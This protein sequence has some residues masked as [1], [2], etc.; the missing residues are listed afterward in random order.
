MLSKNIILCICV[1][2][3]VVCSGFSVVFA[4]S[5]K[6]NIPAKTIC[7]DQQLQLNGFGTRTKFFI[8][9]YV[10]SLYVQN[11]LSDANQFLEMEQVSCMRLQITSSKITSK[12]MIN[13][14]HEGFEKATKGNT[15]PIKKEIKTFSSYLEQPIKKGDLFEF[16]YIPHQAIHIIKNGSRL[17]VIENKEFAT[18]FFAI[19]LGEMPAQEKLKHG[20]LGQL[21]T[22]P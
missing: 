17:G 6:V 15:D 13:A 4:D 2:L 18:A 7:A 1:F 14:I 22:L 11:R 10:A 21:Q 5:V 8:K 16:T 12:K 20:L 3:I 9:L 19:W